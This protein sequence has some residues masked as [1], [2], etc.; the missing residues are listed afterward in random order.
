DPVSAPLPQTYCGGGTLAGC[1]SVLLASLS[2]AATATF[3]QVCPGDSLCGAGA[4]WCADSIVQSA[5]GGI[6]HPPISWQNRP[7][8]QQVIEFPAHR[9]D[10]IGNLANGKTADR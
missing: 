9:G 3:A 2:Q 1:R 10:N 7:T 8:Y 5:L 6:T 4:Q